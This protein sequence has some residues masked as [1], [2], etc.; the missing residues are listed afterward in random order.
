MVVTELNTNV[1]YDK[2]DKNQ[3]SV[4]DKK[5]KKQIEN[6]KAK[7]FKLDIEL[8]NV[9]QY[10]KI[11]TLNEISQSLIDLE[12]STTK[13]Q[14]DF[15]KPYKKVLHETFGYSYGYLKKVKHNLNQ[16]LIDIQDEIRHEEQYLNPNHDFNIKSYF[17]Q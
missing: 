1:I 2:I 11:M 4:Q 17:K 5:I 12:K 7:T 15:V 8:F 6:L 14:R 10:Q 9:E 3:L 13:K 16:L